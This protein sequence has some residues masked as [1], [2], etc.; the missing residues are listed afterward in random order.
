MVGAGPSDITVDSNGNVYTANYYDSTVTKITP[1][2][3]S[4]VFGTTG[5]GPNGIVVDMSGNV[6]TV[7]Q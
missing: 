4:S 6:Y 7:N 1:D 3:N 5:K 2:G